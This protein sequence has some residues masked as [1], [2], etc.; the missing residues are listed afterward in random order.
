M[1]TPHAAQAPSGETAYDLK[2]MANAIRALAMDAVQA[3]NSGHPGMPM[4][5]ADVA[6]VLYTK[7]LKFDPK[8]P[9]WADRDRFI[10][11]AGHGSMLL[12]ALNY[13][14]GYEK[15]TLEEIK[16]FRQLGHIT[17]G[18]PEVEPDAGIE[19]TTGPLGQ[20]ISTA[21]GMA[22]AERMLNAR[23]GDDLVNHYTYV[24]ASDG[25]MMEG[26]SHEACSLAGHMRLSKLIVLYD[27]NGIC[28]DGATST[29]FS[30]NTPQRFEAYGWDTATVD[31]H[32]FAAIEAAIAAAQKSNKPSLICCKT[33]IGFGAPTKENSASSHG[34]PLGEEEI[35]GARKNLDWP[36][37]PFEVPGDVLDQWRSVG[38]RAYQAQLDWQARLENSADKAAFLKAL[39]K[40]I[41]Q[42]IAPLIAE[43]KKAFAADRP[44]KATRQTSGTVLEKLVPAV[45]EMV[46]GSA[47]LTGS[48]NTI[49]KDRGI[50]SKSD[51]K[52]Q[53]IHYGV[54][55]HAMAAMMNGMALHGGII[56]YSGTFLQFADYSRP[57]IRLGALMKQRVI[58]VMTHDSIGLGE[59]GPTH[60]PVEH[61]AA[62]R[63]IP[64]LYVFRPC[65]G[66]ETAECWELAL[67]LKSSPSVMALTRQGLP[68]VREDGAENLSA[69]GAYIL[70]DS[71]GAPAV[72]LFASGSE[73]SIALEAAERLG[74][75]TRIVSVPCMD[76][77][78]EQDGAYIQSLIC[79]DSIKVGIEAAIRQGWDG[80]IGAHSPFI[81]MN[82]F[83][84]SAPAEELYRHFGITADA[85]VKA[86]EEKRR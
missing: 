75:Q 14:T 55:E 40:D 9:E 77:F 59:D 66:V 86:V 84:A 61:L 71:E 46:G 26:I 52:G 81:G 49:V 17:A 48:N 62:L 18:H 63:A 69:R 72:T 34:A 12:Y 42:D 5:M 80:I 16:N 74:P 65:D 36:H 27:D 67:N 11:S 35:A 30:D 64:N 82:G 70:K 8:N 29:S 31:G 1:T 3:A 45:Q 20:G 47:D 37:G 6:T 19:M 41:A 23:F 38:Q 56:P 68:T 10:L 22:L 60:Q 73:V 44:K 57:A 32:D 83:G 7:F 15:M 43:V 28:I 78:R 13:L 33:K 79:N 21:P 54:R 53:Y 50:V 25:D 39:N 51:Y 85:V 76:L 4:G 24:I 58:H 2:R